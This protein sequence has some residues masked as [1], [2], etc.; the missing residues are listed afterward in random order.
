MAAR[1]ALPLSPV[2]HRCGTA[3]LASEMYRKAVVCDFLFRK[4][5]KFILNGSVFVVDFDF[6]F[7]CA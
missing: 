6:S 7:D 4:G 3:I 1:I 5:L 2:N